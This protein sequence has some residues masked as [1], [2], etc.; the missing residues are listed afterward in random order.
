MGAS[1]ALMGACSDGPSSVVTQDYLDR[2]RRRVK[3]LLRYFQPFE[4]PARSDGKPQIAT[5]STLTA[6][7]QLAALRLNCERS[8]VSLIDNIKQYIVAEA[9]QTISLIDGDLYEGDND[10]LSFGRTVLDFKTGVCPGTIACFTSPDGSLDVST[11]YIKASRSYYV[12]NDMSM[13]EGYKR[14]PYVSGWPHMRYY[15]EVPIHSP[16]G[17]CIGTLCVVDNVGRDGLDLNGIRILK[18]I[19]NAVMDHLELCVSSI[20]QSQAERMIQGLG[21]F[22]EGHVSTRDSSIEAPAAPEVPR[23]SIEERPEIELG[24]ELEDLR[25]S[26]PESLWNDVQSKQNL[27]NVKEPRQP[28]VPLEAQH[29]VQKQLSFDEYTFSSTSA[30]TTAQS[31]PNTDDTLN[32]PFT[33]I[34]NQT[35]DT[36]LN[37]STSPKCTEEKMSKT[38]DKNHI[39]SSALSSDSLDGILFRAANL[40]RETICLD[41]VAFFD[42]RAADGRLLT[43]TIVT[44]EDTTNPKMAPKIPHEA[45][46]SSS[47]FDSHSTL[48]RVMSYSIKGKRDHGD[49]IKMSEETL[50]ILLKQFPRGGL[51]TFDSEGIVGVESLKSTIGESRSM[52]HDVSP[53]A[54]PQDSFSINNIELPDTELRRI[55]PGVASLIVYPFLDNIH[56]NPVAH[57]MAWTSEPARAFRQQ[58]FAYI[59]SFSHSVVAELSRLEVVAA[60]KAKSRFISSIS[61]ELRSPLHGIM[62]SMEIL[63]DL[64]S[65]AS[66]QDL[67]STIESCGSTLLDTIDNVLAFSQT[68]SQMTKE[69]GNL[70]LKPLQSADGPESAIDME[71]LVEEVTSICL[72][73]VQ[74]RMKVDSSAHQKPEKPRHPS[75][76]DDVVVICDITRGDWLFLTNGAVWNRILLNLVGNALKYTSSGFIVVILRQNTQKESSPDTGMVLGCQQPPSTDQTSGPPTTV[77]RENSETDS[78]VFR[79]RS[80]RVLTLS[81]KDSGKGMSKDYLANF[82]FKPFYQENPLAPGTGLGLSIVER[83]VRSIGG[84]INVISEEGVGTEVTV[85]VPLERPE[86]HFETRSEDLPPFSNA[87]LGIVGLDPMTNISETQSRIPPSKSE[88]LLALS[89][90]IAKYASAANLDT[91]PVAGLD[92]GTADILFIQDSQYRLLDISQILALKKPLVVLCLEPLRSHEHTF[93]KPMNVVLLSNPFGPRKFQQIIDSCLR[94][95]HSLLEGSV[96]G[97]IPDI[98]SNPPAETTVLVSQTRTPSPTN[99]DLKT[100]PVSDIKQVGPSLL[101]VEDNPINLRLLITSVSRMGYPFTTATNGLEAVEAY[102][103]S[104]TQIILVFMD[105]QMPVMDG[106]EASREIRSYERQNS[107]PRSVIVA[108]TALD[109]PDAKQAAIDSGVDLFFTKP[110]SVKK[111]KELVKEHYN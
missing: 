82:L 88:G 47:S 20:Q 66:F 49:H 21:H 22:V 61:H 12:M 108:L 37:P 57:C 42:P 95:R 4:V 19:S 44:S 9:T 26:R 2:E 93:N 103:A 55:L 33:T 46:I 84:K 36:V 56:D 34:E 15:A 101:L 25:I 8:F 53:T 104:A 105:I 69:N 23:R 17:T 107:L 109:S 67:F 65:N 14:R 39:N 92:C 73:G 52:V 85:E 86:E 98:N 77:T 64:T 102:K 110:V 80:R 24:S 76:W 87:R 29:S 45:N 6:F 16:S 78:S 97:V 13:L 41:G 111:L 91:I 75:K 31:T 96:V 54:T 71:V 38:E 81:V 43:D 18:E 89:S 51:V 94:I 79:D 30:S 62:A 58:E 5:D 1:T 10:E 60:D 11:T 48:S 100:T 63:R 59:A 32:S 74:F 27:Q 40:I 70:L 7:A 90:T 28:I 72:T 3:E 106:I 50:Q 35:S 68:S 99:D 83:L